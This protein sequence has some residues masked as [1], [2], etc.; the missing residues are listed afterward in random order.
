MFQ[1]EQ[2]QNKYI[3]I[4][5]KVKKYVNENTKFIMNPTVARKLLNKGNTYFYLEDYCLKFNEDQDTLMDSH[6]Q[7]TDY[8]DIVK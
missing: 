4:K 8:G 1:G 2:W 5:F 3:R 7:M 6:Y